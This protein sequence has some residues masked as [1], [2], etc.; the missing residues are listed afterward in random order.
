MLGGQ[1]QKVDWVCCWLSVE[2]QRISRR[3]VHEKTN[4]WT[5]D[6]QKKGKT[7]HTD[8]VAGRRRC[9]SDN[10]IQQLFDNSG[11]W[12]FVHAERVLKY[13]YAKTTRLLGRS[14]SALAI[15][16][17]SCKHLAKA[18][19][20]PVRF[21]QGKTKLNKA[22]CDVIP[23]DNATQKSQNWQD[24]ISV[25]RLYFCR[26]GTILKVHGTHALWWGAHWTL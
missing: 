4:P 14:Q 12:R 9:P 17:G 25:V 13:S 3:S 8:V 24:D 22:F 23:A 19:L 10:Q 21:H 26:S 11:A 2:D 18:G 7:R 20:W 1:Y 15:H 5:K 6:C 16:H